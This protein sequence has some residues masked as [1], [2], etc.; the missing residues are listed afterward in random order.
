MKK[1][2]KYKRHKEV[3]GVLI[4]D[5]CDW[6]QHPILF[7]RLLNKLKRYYTFKQEFNFNLEDDAYPY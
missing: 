5:I 2:R 4:A 6:K 3:Y 1:K 7:R